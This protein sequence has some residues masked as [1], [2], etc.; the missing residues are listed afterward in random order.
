M[1][2]GHFEA[3]VPIGAT[4]DAVWDA[5]VNPAKLERWFCEHADVSLVDRR[6]DFWG[7][8]TPDVPSREEGRH[9]VVDVVHG[10]LLSYEWRI[11]GLVTEV[12]IRL[13]EGDGETVV[14]LVHDNMPEPTEETTDV[15]GFWSLA[16]THGL[17]GLV[18]FGISGG[19][20]FDFTLPSV[21]PDRTVVTV[22]VDA[23]RERVYETL[24]GVEQEWWVPDGVRHKVRRHPPREVSTPFVMEGAH[25]SVLTWT[26][27]ESEGRT[28]LTLVHHG[29]GRGEKGNI[30]G[31][32]GWTD[33][34]N[35]MKFVA[36]VGPGWLDR[37]GRVRMTRWDGSAWR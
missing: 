14:H 2:G 1:N 6:Y 17:R 22:D 5:L 28:R 25:E 13:E 8:Y 26:L 23:P 27:E 36:E 3:A 35:F 12:E 18:E 37:H 30:R 7:R 15:P 10:S 21:F 4:A 11:R 31:A 32:I 33:Q 34:V 19:G 16:L 24:A 20:R 29:F 9:R